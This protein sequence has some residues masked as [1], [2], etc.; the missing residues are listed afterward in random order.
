[1][2]PYALPERVTRDLERVR[3]FRYVQKSHQ[4][5][6]WK[7]DG[8]HPSFKARRVRWMPSEG[9]LRAR[10]P[11]KRQVSAAVRREI[12]GRLSDDSRGGFN[13]TG[14]RSELEMW[15]CADE[16]QR[17]ESKQNVGLSD[18]ILTPT[19]TLTVGSPHT[20]HLD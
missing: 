15:R 1:M 14:Q 6:H 3:Y 18:G 10:R 4:S 13:L 7:Y 9:E 11:T 8:R 17:K 20:T 19:P 5:T 16:E 12:R 2:A